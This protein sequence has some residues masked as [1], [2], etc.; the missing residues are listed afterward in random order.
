LAQQD[1]VEEAGGVMAP[2]PAD[3]AIDP[4]EPPLP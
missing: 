1:M 2:I 4:V 3:V